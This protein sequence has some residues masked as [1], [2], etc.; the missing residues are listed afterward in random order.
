MNRRSPSRSHVSSVRPAAVY[1]VS[2]S[3]LKPTPH[4]PAECPVS[5]LPAFAGGDVPHDGGA[6]VGARGEQLAAG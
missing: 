4:T 5:T 1:S 2:S 3:G 6:I